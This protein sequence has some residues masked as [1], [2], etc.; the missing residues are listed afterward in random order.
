MSLL[1]LIPMLK[2]DGHQPAQTEEQ[3]NRRQKNRLH[4]LNERQSD[5]DVGT[6]N[7]VAVHGLDGHPYE[8]W[9]APQSKELWLRDYLPQDLPGARVFSFGYPCEV[10]VTRSR[11]DVKDLALMLLCSLDQVCYNLPLK[12]FSIRK[13]NNALCQD[14]PTTHY[15]YLSRRG[16]HYSQTGDYTLIIFNIR[17]YL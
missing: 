7:I 11:A 10:G 12:T 15:I 9:I 5:Q 17:I 6:L 1:R 8:T 2:F 13:L 3:K 4:F 14:L 16:R